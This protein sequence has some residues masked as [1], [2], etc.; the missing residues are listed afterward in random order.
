MTKDNIEANLPWRVNG[1]LS[2]RELEELEQILQYSDNWQ[3]E[4]DWLEIV[5]TN[6]K[7][8]PD[9][10][11]L[12]LGWRQLQRDIHQ[13]AIQHEKSTKHQHKHPRWPLALAIAAAAIL[14][15]QGILLYGS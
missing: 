7:Q 4:I 5:Q 15:L 8:E 13:Q 3:P 10:A 1:S 14:L 9:E 6:I 12:E 11:P 2:E